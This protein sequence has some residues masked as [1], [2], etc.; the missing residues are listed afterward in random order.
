MRVV[1]VSA[2]YFA[3]FRVGCSSEKIDAS[4]FDALKVADMKL[5]MLFM[6]APG[7]LAAK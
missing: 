3:K 2:K 4:L 6:I 1:D 7:S 5:E